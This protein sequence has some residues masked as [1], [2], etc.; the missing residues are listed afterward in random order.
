[1]A[2]L[3]EE[4]LMTPNQAAH[5]KLMGYIEMEHSNNLEFTL[6]CDLSMASKCIRVECETN[7]AYSVYLPNT[8]R[9]ERVQDLIK[10]LNKLRNTHE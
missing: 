5:L 7:E 1:M 2:E 9:Q 6:M 8:L 3:T 10:A 4:G